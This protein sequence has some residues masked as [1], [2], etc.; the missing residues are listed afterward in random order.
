ME[1]QRCIRLPG[2]AIPEWLGG[3]IVCGVV[4]IYVTTG[5]MRGTAWVNTF[6]T[7]VFMIF[8]AIAFFVIVKDMGGLTEAMSQ[9]AQKH[10]ELLVPSRTK[11]NRS[12]CSP[13]LAFRFQ[14][15]CFLIFSF[16]G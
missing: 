9:V 14:P 8:G 7:L 10:P 2:G 6:Q 3:L 13:T 4:L 12:N 5:G 16:T 11:F 15:E 1:E